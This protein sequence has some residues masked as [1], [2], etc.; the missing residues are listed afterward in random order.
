MLCERGRSLGGSVANISAFIFPWNNSHD[1]ITSLK[2]RRRVVAKHQ[3][4]AQSAINLRKC[5]CSNGVAV[6]P[7][8]PRTPSLSYFVKND[9]VN[10]R[11]HVKQ[12]V[13]LAHFWSG[14]RRHPSP[15]APSAFFFSVDLLIESVRCGWM[16]PMQVRSVVADSYRSRRQPLIDLYPLLGAAS[17]L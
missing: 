7:H 8:L 1:I 10:L 3:V 13:V 17:A 2:V 6:P 9:E 12:L 11:R 15:L 16:G 5:L 14:I 4:C